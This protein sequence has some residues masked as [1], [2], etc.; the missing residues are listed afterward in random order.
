M[1]GFILAGTDS[2]DACTFWQYEKM[3]ENAGF[4]KTTQYSVPDRRGS[5]FSREK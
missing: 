4:L 1:A 3:F 5:C 2:D